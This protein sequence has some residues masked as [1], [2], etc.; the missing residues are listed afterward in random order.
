MQNIGLMGLDPRY[1]ELIQ[2]G[3]YTNKEEEY[4]GMLAK[5]ILVLRKKGN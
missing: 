3:P 5:K 2:D 4:E 1:L